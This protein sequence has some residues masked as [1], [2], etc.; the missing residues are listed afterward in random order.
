MDATEALE[1]VRRELTGTSQARI[2][3]RIGV[4]DGT[5]SRWLSLKARPEGEKRERLIAWAS[6]L[7]PVQTPDVLTAAILATAKSVGVLVRVNNELLED[8]PNFAATIDAMVAG[9]LAQK[10]DQLALYGP[11]A[12]QVLGLR[13]A[14]G[15]AEQTMGGNGGALAD[16]DDSEW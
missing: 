8:S 6:A 11:G 3:A 13:D 5:L 9:G 7:P 12:G 10:M 4:S 14:E 1:V 15:L 2:A 16:F